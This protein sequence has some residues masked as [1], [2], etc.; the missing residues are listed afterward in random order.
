MRFISV[1]IR[2]RKLIYGAFYEETN[3]IQKILISLEFENNMTSPCSANGTNMILTFDSKEDLA[4]LPLVSVSYK[5][6]VLSPVAE[7]Q[8]LFCQADKG[9]LMLYFKDESLTIVNNASTSDLKEKLEQLLS[10]SVVNVDN[11]NTDKRICTSEG[12]TSIIQFASMA[13]SSDGDQPLLSINDATFASLLSTKSGCGTVC[14][15]DKVS[16]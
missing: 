9:N 3:D 8:T 13:D 1:L 16:E 4:N 2:L 10:I 14:Q 15:E 5:N 11:D 6:L 12:T 7:E